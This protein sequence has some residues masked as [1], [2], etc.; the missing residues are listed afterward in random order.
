MMRETKRMKSR[1]VFPSS[2]QFL[3]LSDA[4]SD[5]INW[6]YFS[7][8]S[9]SLYESMACVGIM[10]SLSVMMAKKPAVSTASSYF[11]LLSSYPFIFLSSDN[12]TLKKQY[13]LPSTS[14]SGTSSPAC[15]ITFNASSWPFTF[16]SVAIIC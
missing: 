11:S 9:L 14:A 15:C 2:D 12:S 4:V 7:C 8:S 6:L 5:F 10:S 16:M 3:C 13:S 1:P